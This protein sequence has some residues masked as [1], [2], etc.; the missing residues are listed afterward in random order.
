[1]NIEN[2]SSYDNHQ[3][4][5]FSNPNL[6]HKD[7]E[8]LCGIISGISSD[9]L[10]NPLEHS[11]LNGWLQKTKQYESRQPYK[12][13]IE[14]I[15]D[16]VKDDVFTEEEGKNIIWFCNQYLKKNAYYDELTAGILKLHGVVKGISIDKVININELEYLDAWLDNNEYLKN[17]WPYDELYNITTKIIRD[18]AI[19]NNEHDELLRFC[20]ALSS[21]VDDNHANKDV[22]STLSTGF[23][24][25]DPSIVFEERTFCITG[26]S[27]KYKRKEIGEKIE[28]LGGFV[29][30]NVSGKLNY[31][32]VC[33]EQNSCWAFSCYGRKIEE[34]MYQ[35]REGKQL[36]IVHEYD[37]FDSMQNYL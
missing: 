8:Y 19:D 12:A 2:F 5:T 23:F 31:L 15:R 6:V 10:I 34:A 9:H 17:T 37:L 18:K 3:Y 11:G 4:H 35:R 28:L 25:I 29:Q 33:D 21:T 27:K 24:Q 32:V 26:V 36:V 14:L 1:M 13:I 30:N 22:L 7:L 16:A 20:Q